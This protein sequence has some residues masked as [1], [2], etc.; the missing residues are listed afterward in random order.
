[1][2]LF[3][4]LY[5]ISVKSRRFVIAARFAKLYE[6]LIT[7][8]SY[9]FACELSR[10]Y[11]SDCAL[12]RSQVLEQR[13]VSALARINLACINAHLRETFRDQPVVLGFITD[14]ASESEL[15]IKL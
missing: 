6:A 11:T 4:M 9:G 15:H 2:M 14:L 3:V 7:H 13:R 12:K 5:S 8:E 10:C 1:M